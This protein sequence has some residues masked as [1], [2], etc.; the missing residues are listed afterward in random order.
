M[1]GSAAASAVK[2]DRPDRRSIY[3]VAVVTPELSELSLPFSLSHSLTRS[4]ARAV[5]GYR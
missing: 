3:E 1:N 5:D 2:P 4:V